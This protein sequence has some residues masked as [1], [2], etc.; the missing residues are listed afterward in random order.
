MCHI[1]LPNA[2]HK[3]MWFSWFVHFKLILI[4]VIKC[5]WN[6]SISPWAKLFKNVFKVDAKYCNTGTTYLFGVHGPIQTALSEGVQ[7][8]QVFFSW[9][10]ER[11]SKYHFK[12]AIISPPAKCHLNGVSL[13]YRCWPNIKCWLRTFMIFW[14]IRTSIARKPYIFVIFQGGPDTLYPL[15]TRAWCGYSQIPI[16]FDK[17]F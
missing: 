8:W 1:L 3:V 17:S 5:H 11:G 6:T 7:I 10:G 12:W 15:W 13:A 9:W 16:G 14:G 4:V 2:Y